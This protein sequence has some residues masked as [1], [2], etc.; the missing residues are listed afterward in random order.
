MD[1]RKPAPERRF[2]RAVG[3]LLAPHLALGREALRLSCASAAPQREHELRE[4][5]SMGLE[6]GGVRTGS[7]WRYMPH[8][9]PPPWEA[10]YQ[11]RQRWIK[12]GVFEEVLHDLRVLFLRLS[13]GR[14]PEPMAAILDSPTPRSTPQSGSRGGYA[15][16]PSPRRAPT[17]CTRRWTL[18]GICS[19]CM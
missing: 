3:V 18:W 19:P 5:F 2:R 15:M 14:A 7:P 10:P 16:G 12:A 9:L 11:Q 1:T 17:R 6:V 4:V 8:I 13:E